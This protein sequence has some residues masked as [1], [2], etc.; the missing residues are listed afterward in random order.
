[1]T[2]PQDKTHSQRVCFTLW[3]SVTLALGLPPKDNRFVSG[4]SR[5]NAWFIWGAEVFLLDASQSTQAFFL[6]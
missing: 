1:M 5:V 3:R 4:F 6:S 2:L